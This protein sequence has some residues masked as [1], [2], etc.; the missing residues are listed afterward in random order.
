M[1]GCGCTYCTPQYEAPRSN[2]LG[3]IRPIGGERG[4]YF[5]TLEP[6]NTY[7]TLYCARLRLKCPV[8]LD[9]AKPIPIIYRP[10]F[11]LNLLYT[12]TYLY[13][14]F[15]CQL[16]SIKCMYKLLTDLQ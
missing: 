7:N 16:I 8:I 1:Y 5:N 14:M 4:T 10:M 3:L 11:L 9:L 12:Q 2:T 6:N 13:N 15:K